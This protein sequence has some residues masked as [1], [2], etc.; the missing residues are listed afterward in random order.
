MW[1]RDP[2]A[3]VAILY[4]GSIKNPLSLVHKWTILVRDYG[5]TEFTVADKFDWWW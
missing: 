3:K 2:R 1:P 4:I 5:F